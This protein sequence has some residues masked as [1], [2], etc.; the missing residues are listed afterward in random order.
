MKRLIV[1]DVTTDSCNLRFRWNWFSIHLAKNTRKRIRYNVKFSRNVFDGEIVILKTNC[2]TGEPIG[3]DL[4]VV[5]V[6]EGLVIGTT[7][8]VTPMGQSP[9]DSKALFHRRA[10]L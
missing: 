2:P 5:Q 1:G 4:H 6:R 9:Y 10:M 7:R 8:K 3:R